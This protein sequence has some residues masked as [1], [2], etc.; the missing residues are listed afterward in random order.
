MGIKESLPYILAAYIGIWVILFAYV[1][2][3]QNKLA[4]IKKELASL[5]RVLDRKAKS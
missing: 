4:G 5:G 1:I 2:L 3:M